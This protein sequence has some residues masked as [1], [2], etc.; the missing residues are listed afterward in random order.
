M[1]RPGGSPF[2]KFVLSLNHAPGGSLCE[3]SQGKNFFIRQR[4][5]QENAGTFQ[6]IAGDA[7]QALTRRLQPFSAVGRY[8]ARVKIAAILGAFAA[9]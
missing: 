8:I 9:V 4:K 2:V 7:V 6:N 3:Q 1:S 5:T